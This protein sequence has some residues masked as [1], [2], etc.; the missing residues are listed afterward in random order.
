MCMGYSGM[1]L[2][3][4]GGKERMGGEEGVVEKG[5]KERGIEGGAQMLR[6][7]YLAR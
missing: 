6:G 2:L 4:V 7:G 1:V 3:A 5:L